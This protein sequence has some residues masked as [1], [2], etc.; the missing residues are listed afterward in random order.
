MKRDKEAAGKFQHFLLPFFGV[1]EF[2]LIGFFFLS[3]VR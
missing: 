3:L 2:Q 1:S